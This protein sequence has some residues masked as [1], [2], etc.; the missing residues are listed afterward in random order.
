MKVSII[1]P[2]FN[3]ENYVAAC[4]DSALAQTYGD[5]EIIAVNDGST[6]GSAEILQSYVQ[7]PRV[8]VISQRNGGLSAARNSGLDA[9]AGDY[10]FFLDSDDTIHPET[11]E[12][13]LSVAEKTDAD[14]VRC[15]Y[16]V[17]YGELD[18]RSPHVEPPAVFELLDAPVEDYLRH[19]FLPS[20]CLCLY[21]RSTFGDMRFTRDVIF[22][23]LD[24]TWRYLRR[25]RRGAYMDFAAYNYT[26]TESSL[27]R[28]GMTPKKMES[29]AKCIELVYGDYLAHNDSRVEK[30][31]RGLFP[32]V[33]KAGLLKTT[34]GDG[35]LRREADAL[36]GRLLARGIVRVRDFHPRWWWRLLR[37]RMAAGGK[38]D[39]AE[40]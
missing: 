13:L 32:Y 24:F 28:S 17:V 1:I 10:I 4:L 19:R 38:K 18:A 8:C 9:A 12:Q 34:S 37:A 5:L 7:D 2:V 21:R 35:N 11:I 40:W 6:D 29:F 20:A 39:S 31:Q 27:T 14:F 25:V 15:S 23:D 22:E 33:I 30:L 16:R 3:A 26:Q 36:I